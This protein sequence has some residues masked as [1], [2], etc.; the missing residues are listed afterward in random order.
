MI[1]I[2]QAILYL[3]FKIQLEDPILCCQVDYMTK[4][5]S[6]VYDEVFSEFNSLEFCKKIINHELSETA[7][8]NRIHQ[9]NETERLFALAVL[10]KLLWSNTNI[11]G[12]GCVI[13]NRI[14][15]ECELNINDVMNQIHQIDL[16]LQI[17]YN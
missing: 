17:K 13:Y 1:T 14:V 2:N 5:R 15:E 16:N 4:N 8:L 7:A 6:L 3:A 9:L 12:K 10:N 11:K